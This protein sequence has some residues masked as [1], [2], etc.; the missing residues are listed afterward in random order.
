M[1]AQ[2]MPKFLLLLLSALLFCPPQSVAQSEDQD[3]LAAFRSYVNH[4]LSSYK[5][6]KREEVTMFGGGWAKE[7]FEPDVASASIDVEKTNSLISPYTASLTFKMIRHR[8]AL[9]QT[10]EGAANDSQFT[11]Q[12]SWLHEHTYAY[13]DKQ[14]VPKTRRCKTERFAGANWSHCDEVITTGEN[15]GEHDINGCLEEYDD[16]SPASVK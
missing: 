14:W 8:T 12:D 13:Q 15:A 9:H 5:Q 2:G 7:Y 1:G 16:A 4:H 10:K 6:N 11:D 3:A